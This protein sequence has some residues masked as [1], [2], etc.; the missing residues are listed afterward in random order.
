MD[1]DSGGAEKERLQEGAF[2][3]NLVH[4][5]DVRRRFEGGWGGGWGGCR[6]AVRRSSAPGRSISAGLR[7]EARP[8]VLDLR[9]AFRKRRKGSAEAPPRSSQAQQGGCISSWKPATLASMNQR[10]SVEP[11]N[12][13]QEHLW[14]RSAIDRM[15][16]QPVNPFHL[17]PG[18]AGEQGRRSAKLNSSTDDAL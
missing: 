9:G 8:L 7:P 18:F 6:R 13:F 5:N 3:S 2:R 17:P 14:P 10:I 11:D 1:W 4:F 15:K 16:A 12:A